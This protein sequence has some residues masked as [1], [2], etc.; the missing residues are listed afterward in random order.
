V[1][2]DQTSE[3]SK[4]DVTVSRLTYERWLGE[5]DRIRAARAFF[6]RQLGPLPV[7]AGVSVALVGT[8]SEKIKDE[9]WLWIALS[10][11]AVMVAASIL[12]SRMPAYRELRSYRVREESTREGDEADNPAA[13]YQAESD[14]ERGI[15]ASDGDRDWSWRLPRRNLGGN[16]Q[17]QLDKERFGVFLVQ[18]LFLLVIAC[19]V[20]AR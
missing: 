10:V 13:W 3:P 15:Y 5:R 20:L 11:F 17:E 19:L 7:F 1:N 2:T 8:F 6:A 16:L 14:L 12:Y 4:D 9:T 18:T